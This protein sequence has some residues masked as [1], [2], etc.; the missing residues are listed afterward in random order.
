MLN[1]I[2]VEEN[3]LFIYL[4]IFLNYVVIVELGTTY[5]WSLGAM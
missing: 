5:I 1:P 3:V 2:I 4:F